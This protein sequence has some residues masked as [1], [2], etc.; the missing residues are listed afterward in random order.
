MAHRDLMERTSEREDLPEKLC[1]SL[2][3]TFSV[4]CRRRV[5]QSARSFPV[6]FLLRHC[7]VGISAEAAGMQRGRRVNTINSLIS[8]VGDTMEGETRV[9]WHN[10]E[11]PYC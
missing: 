4:W 11:F 10:Q 3:Q 1:I 6:Y 7:N 5:N 9:I 2:P 8:F